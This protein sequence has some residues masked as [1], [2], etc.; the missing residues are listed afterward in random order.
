MKGPV[1]SGNERIWAG[2]HTDAPIARTGGLLKAEEDHRCQLWEGDH[3][4]NTVNEY[5][6]SSKPQD[7]I[8][9]FEEGINQRVVT[10]SEI[11]NICCDILHEICA[12]C[13]KGGKG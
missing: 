12:I 11:F 9:Q 4:A 6:K 2:D 1:P 13:L 7:T 10:N 8:Q 5:A 3:K